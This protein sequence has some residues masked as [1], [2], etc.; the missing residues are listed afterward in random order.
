MGVSYVKKILKLS[1]SLY[2]DLETGDCRREEAQTQEE[3]A[4]RLTEGQLKILNCLVRNQNHVCTWDMLEELFDSESGDGRLAATKN[5]VSRLKKT[6]GSVDARFGTEMAKDVFQSVHGRGYLFRLPRHG[7]IIERKAPV[8]GVV[9]ID[10]GFIKSQKLE[11]GLELENLKNIFFGITGDREVIL[12]AVC[13]DIHIS[14]IEYQKL[15]KEFSR[16]V[17]MP[18]WPVAPVYLMADGGTGKSTMLCHFAVQTAEDRPGW[19][20][21]YLDIS[22]LGCEKDTF[23]QIFAYLYQN[24]VSRTRKNVLCVDSP[25]EN[26]KGFRE[27]YEIYMEERN[28]YIYL[29]VAE[30]AALM[31]NLLESDNIFQRNSFIRGFYLDNGEEENADRKFF[32]SSYVQFEDVK[33]RLFPQELKEKVARRMIMHFVKRRSLDKEAVEESMSALTYTKK[34]ISDIFMDFKRGYNMSVQRRTDARPDYYIPQIAMDW[35]EWKMKCRPL[36]SDC[37]RL[38]FSE[39][40]AFIAA[41]Y[42]FR[43]KITYTFVQKMTGYPYKSEVQRLF[44]QG[45]GESTQYVK[46]FFVLR[47]DTV[48]DNYFTCHPE[49]EVQS[50]MEELIVQSYLDEETML[51]FLGKIFLFSYYSN[52]DRVPYGLNLKRL[53]RLFRMNPEYKES[54]A[55]NFKADVVEFAH[56]VLNYDLDSDGEENRKLQKALSDSFRYVMEKLPHKTDKDR[57]WKTYFV[58]SLQYCNKMPEA[59]A[60]FMRPIVMEYEIILKRLID[61]V[62]CQRQFFMDIKWEQRCQRFINSV[63][64]GE[65]LK[66]FDFSYPVYINLEDENC[67]DFMY[68]F[69][70]GNGEADEYDKNRGNLIFYMEQLEDMI[71]KKKNGLDLRRLFVRWQ[72]LPDKKELVIEDEKKEDVGKRMP[73]LFRIIQ[74]LLL[75]HVYEECYEVL[76]KLDYEKLEEEDKY[77]MCV[78]LGMIY[79]I[80]PEE[81]PYYNPELAIEYYQRALGVYDIVD[82]LCK[83]VISDETEDIWLAI[84][85]L[86]YECGQYEEAKKV[87]EKTHRYTLFFSQWRSELLAKLARRE[88]E[89]P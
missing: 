36:D 70:V 16:Y 20:V 86:Y 87:C 74:E 4:C 2:V 10:W 47:H 45:M 27:L 28:P 46:D 43:I 73:Y 8:D 62:Y 60:E 83:G 40:F 52:P 75:N 72:G 85:N 64:Q 80:F 48:A 37:T 6:L 88:M 21:Y 17:F 35:D 12:Q 26:P 19:N 23:R 41:I 78:S 38:K 77:R 56:I 11:P 7:K 1:D 69:L 59:L 51:E 57:C 33:R 63:F 24:G 54:A 66:R 25:H 67:L 76:E 79:S 53:V 84:A 29:V 32:R 89:E 42:L 68:L 65:K 81:N 50:C 18:D 3:P 15:L 13:N 71:P 44:R 14:D 49:I 5:H 9:Q 82:N 55:K 34:T 58:I 30:R 39:V 61:R 22:N 31:M